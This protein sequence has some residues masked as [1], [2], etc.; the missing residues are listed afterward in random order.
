MQP[1]FETRPNIHV[2]LL[3]SVG[4]KRA[5]ALTPAYS[6]LTVRLQRGYIA[7]TV[8]TF[9]LLKRRNGLLRHN[10]IRYA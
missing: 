3:S 9:R 6:A 2:P 4:G 1:D 10:G 8:R 5:C 7:L